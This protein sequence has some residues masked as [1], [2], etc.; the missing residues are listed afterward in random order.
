VVYHRGGIGE[1]QQEIQVHGRIY[2]E[3]RSPCRG[4]EDRVQRDI[5]ATSAAVSSDSRDM[6]FV[7]LGPK[8]IPCTDQVN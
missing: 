3:Y 4:N 6:V 1:M 7:T 5:Y 8:S 2:P